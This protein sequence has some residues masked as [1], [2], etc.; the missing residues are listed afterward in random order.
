MPRHDPYLRDR[1]VSSA[2]GMNLVGA[3]VFGALLGWAIV[4]WFDL[5]VSDGVGAGIGAVVGFV[6]ATGLLFQY[7][8]RSTR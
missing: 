1:N 7:G 2:A 8:G 6:L 5:R 4:G 3:I